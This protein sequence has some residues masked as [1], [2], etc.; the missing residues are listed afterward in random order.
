MAYQLEFIGMAFQIFI[1][2]SLFA[3]S[4]ALFGELYGWP[5]VSTPIKALLWGAAFSTIQCAGRWALLPKFVE[6]L[7]FI[8]PVA[9][10]LALTLRS[11][12]TRLRRAG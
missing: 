9:A 6:F 4:L 8:L 12:R 5:G 7:G 11:T 1:A 10:A 2:W 3:A